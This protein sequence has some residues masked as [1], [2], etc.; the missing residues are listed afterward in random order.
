M[1]IVSESLCHWRK[2]GKNSALL[3]GFSHFPGGVTFV[4]GHRLLIAVSSRVGFGVMVLFSSGFCVFWG[5]GVLDAVGK[6]K[7][8]DVSMVRA[9][10]FW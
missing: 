1:V 7:Q 4:K 2:S 5:P 9:G 3:S 6:E 8:E 10:R